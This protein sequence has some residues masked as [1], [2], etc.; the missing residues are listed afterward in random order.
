MSFIDGNPTEHVAAICRHQLDVVFVMGGSLGGA[1]IPQVRKGREEGT[2]ASFW[3][4]YLVS[5]Y[6]MQT[7]RDSNLASR[8]AA[9]GRMRD[10]LLTADFAW[11]Q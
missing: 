8:E 10:R 11:I 6:V 5:Q 9:S 7:V 2:I 4:A 1:K 3:H